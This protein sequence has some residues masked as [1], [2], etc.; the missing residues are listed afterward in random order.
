MIQFW[1][2]VVCCLHFVMTQMLF[3]SQHG[4]LMAVYDA[5]GACGRLLAST[6]PVMHFIRFFFCLFSLISHRMQ[7]DDVRAIQL[8]DELPGQRK[9][10]LSRRRRHRTVCSQSVRFLSDRCCWSCRRLIRLRL[11]GSIP[12]EI[13]VLTA[14]NMLCVQL[15]DVPPRRSPFGASHIPPGIFTTTT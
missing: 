12:T 8:I 7:L 2:L 5:L 6:S 14:L 3:E 11:T 9:V 13:G 10:G 15:L 1:L 4:A